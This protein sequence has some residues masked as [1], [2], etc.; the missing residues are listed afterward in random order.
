MLE[1]LDKRII[2]ALQDDLPITPRP[3]REIA[4]RVGVGE[5]EII[6]RLRRYRQQGYLRKMGAV[7][8]HREVGFFANALC[9]WRIPPDKIAE[10]GEKMSSC[11]AVTHCYARETHSDWPYN[12][13][14]MLH[15]QTREECRAQAAELARITG[16]DDYIMLFSTKEWKKSNVRYFQ[17]GEEEI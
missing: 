2:A 12:L 10:A 11:S 9:A 3:Y 17:E 1:A 8:R 15:A 4:E 13:Y 14:V 16:Y 5:R 7:L 6:E